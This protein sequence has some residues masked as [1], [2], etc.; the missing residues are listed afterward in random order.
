VKIKALKGNLISQDF[1]NF[2]T[3][4]RHLCLSNLQLKFHLDDDELDK[5][6]IP[7][8]TMI[9]ASVGINFVHSLNLEKIASLK[10][11][12]SFFNS[13]FFNKSALTIF[14]DR[15]DKMP[16]LKNLHISMSNTCI[17]ELKKLIF[18]LPSTVEKF[19][20]QLAD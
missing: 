9:N 10:L 18:G 1:F 7:K 14:L 20:L 17:K 11:I 19:K 15:I 5:I 8:L 13:I 2:L 4:T 3:S 16:N 12:N 6:E